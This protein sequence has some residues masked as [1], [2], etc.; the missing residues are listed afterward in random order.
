[1]C[2]SPTSGEPVPLV[3]IGS[4]TLGTG[5]LWQAE[6]VVQVR[7]HIANATGLSFGASDALPDQARATHPIGQVIRLDVIGS[8]QLAKQP[9]LKVLLQFSRRTEDHTSADA[10]HL[11]LAALVLERSP[12]QRSGARWRSDYLRDRPRLG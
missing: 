1:M 2:D 5:C 8:E 12:I 11:P 9:L 3:G 10:H 6:F 7:G 4:G